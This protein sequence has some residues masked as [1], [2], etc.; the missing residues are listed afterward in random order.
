M[1][2]Y[3]AKK[4]DR[5]GIHLETNQIIFLLFGGAI[6]LAVIYFFAENKKIKEKFDEVE[7]NIAKLDVNFNNLTKN[8]NVNLERLSNRGNA[9]TDQIERL[10]S[11]VAQQNAM[12][13]ELPPRER[14]LRDLP[15]F[16]QPQRQPARIINHD[17]REKVTATASD[18]KANGNM[19]FDPLTVLMDTDVNSL[20]S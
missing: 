19:K 13:R 14:D 6:A 8:I 10:N 11:I 4:K 20:A 15:D 3:P 18:A 2:T 5:V 17:K 16:P 7:K 1:D 12:F 9:L